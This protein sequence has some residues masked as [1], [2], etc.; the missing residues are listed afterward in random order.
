MDLPELYIS[1][2]SYYNSRFSYYNKVGQSFQ[3][4]RK[5]VLSLIVITIS[6]QASQAPYKLALTQK[7][8]CNKVR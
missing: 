3:T 7:G 1:R 8:C 6:G 5:L 2:F 4:L